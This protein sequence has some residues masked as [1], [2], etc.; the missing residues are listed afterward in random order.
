MSFCHWLGEVGGKGVG[1][2]EGWG[3]DHRSPAE[4]GFDEEKSQMFSTPIT[5]TAALSNT[6][7]TL[8]RISKLP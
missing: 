4:S 7:Y 2:E 6:F 5:D 8:I 1:A 3:T